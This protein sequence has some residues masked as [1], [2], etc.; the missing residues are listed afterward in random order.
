MMFLLVLPPALAAAF[1]ANNFL[2]GV[3]DEFRVT[4]PNL[5]VFI[6]VICFEWQ[7]I[8]PIIDLW[9]LRDLQVK[10]S[11]RGFSGIWSAIFRVTL[12]RLTPR[13]HSNVRVGKSTAQDLPNFFTWYHLGEPSSFKVIVSAG[14]ILFLYLNIAQHISVLEFFR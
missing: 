14:L 11:I 6:V 9:H 12:I 2:D 7:V 4:T 10:P 8:F 3:D 1:Y 13:W 5:F